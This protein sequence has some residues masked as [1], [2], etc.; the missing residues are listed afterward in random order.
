MLEI[1]AVVGASMLM[2]WGWMAEYKLRTSHVLFLAVSKQI[3]ETQD[4]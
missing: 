3:S 4:S 2:K 1:D